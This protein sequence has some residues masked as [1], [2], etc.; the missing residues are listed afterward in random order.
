MSLTRL[1]GAWSS[2]GFLAKSTRPSVSSRSTDS[3]L[4]ASG[5]LFGL[6]V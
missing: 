1:A 6:V 2:A 3:A 5:R 4:S